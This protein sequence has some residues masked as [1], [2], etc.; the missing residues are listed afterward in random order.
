M[1]ICTVVPT[2]SQKNKLSTA[3][4]LGLAACS[5]QP[6]SDKPCRRHSWEAGK[7]AEPKGSSALLQRDVPS[8][9]ALLLFSHHHPANPKPHH[10]RVFSFLGVFPCDIHTCARTR[11]RHWAPGHGRDANTPRLWRLLVAFT[12]LFHGQNTVESSSEQLQ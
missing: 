12:S 7:P 8:V 2:S 5:P 4:V 6:R 3:L 11:E 1:F 9:F 10:I